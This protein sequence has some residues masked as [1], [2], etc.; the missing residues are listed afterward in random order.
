MT[1]SLKNGIRNSPGKAWK[2]QRSWLLKNNKKQL[3]VAQKSLI[4]GIRMAFNWA[5]GEY[6]L[7]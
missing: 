7:S 1:F 6:W 2:F 4:N 5:N 3:F